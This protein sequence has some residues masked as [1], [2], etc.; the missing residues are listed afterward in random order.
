MS[1]SKGY[2]PSLR[3]KKN[4]AQARTPVHWPCFAQRMM[5]QN[6]AAAVIRQKGI[7]G[8]EYHPT[9]LYAICRA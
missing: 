6:R 4:F 8:L 5:E 9:G 7:V 3:R 1:S 2:D